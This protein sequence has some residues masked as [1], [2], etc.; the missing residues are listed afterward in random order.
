MSEKLF[1][2]AEEYDRMLHHGL[3]LTG[4]GKMYFAQGRVQWLK[5]AL[6][7]DAAVTRILDFGCGIGGT[8]KLLA[9]AFPKASVV[10]V[11]TSEQAVQ[12]ACEQHGCERISFTCMDGFKAEAEFDLA[13][14]NGVFHHIT[15]ADRPEALA[16]I[17]RWLRPKGRFALFENNPWNPGTRLVMSRIEFDRD[18]QPISPCRGRRMLREAG[19]RI[20]VA[21]FGFFFPR[22]LGVLRILEPALC[23]IPLGGQFLLLAQVET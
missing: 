5:A 16:C 6:P 20:S 3:S 4:E 19:Y 21:S 8:S 10:G 9:E 11:D 2:L 12:F 23:R 1:D 17:R 15:P 14:C 13:Y 18:A 22:W 7:R